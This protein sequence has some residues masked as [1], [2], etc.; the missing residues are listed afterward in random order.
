[1]SKVLVVDDEPQI[2]EDLNKHL[3]KKGFAVYTA[4][5]IEEARKIILCEDLDYAI[6]DLKIDFSTEFGGIKVVN[7][8]KRN[9]PKVKTLILSA[10]PY[11]DVKE[12]LK[13]ELKGEPDSKK[14]LKEIEQDYV[15]KGGEKNYILAILDKLGELKE[16]KKCFV[17]MPSSTTESCTEEEW[18]KIFKVLIKPVVE[19][20][21]FNYECF[22]S[23]LAHGTIIGNIIDKLNRSDLVIADITD[24]NSNILYEL[25][26]RH[27]LGGPTIVIAQDISHVPSDLQPDMVTIYDW[28]SDEGRNKF[29][30]E[31][32]ECIAFIEDK[33]NK[34]VSLVK[35]YLNPLAIDSV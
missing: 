18:S 33:P 7:F 9:Q 34:A 24:R 23:N 35:R 19:K 31:I 21:G 2:R 30:I 28:K 10:Y 14:I 13:K 25:G 32:K 27:A 15:S 6:I 3:G 1:M 29:K 26:V 12:Q 22:R 8:A 4:S 17:I 16:K 11:K 5:T 20:S